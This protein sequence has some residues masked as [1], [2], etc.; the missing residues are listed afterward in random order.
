[1]HTDVSRL[2]KVHAARQSAG[3]C[4]SILYVCVVCVCGACV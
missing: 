1:M 2:Q 4:V 3:M